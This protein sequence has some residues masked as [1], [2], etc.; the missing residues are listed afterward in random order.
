MQ[1]DAYNQALK[2]MVVAEVTSNLLMRN[3]PACLFIDLTSADGRAT[4][5]LGD[6]VV[7]C[8]LMSTIDA[9]RVDRVIGTLSSAL[10]SG[11]SSRQVR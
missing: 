10:G 1:A 7:S 3:D 6:S 5:L 11:P 8:L 2:T 4:G 9:D